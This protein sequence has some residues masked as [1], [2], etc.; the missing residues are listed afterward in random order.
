MLWHIADYICWKFQFFVLCRHTCQWAAW[1]CVMGMFK[2]QWI[3]GRQCIW[4]IFCC[5]V[6][7]VW[8]TSST[9]SVLCGFQ[10]SRLLATRWQSLPFPSPIPLI[11]QNLLSWNIASADSVNQHMQALC[12]ITHPVPSVLN[13]VCW[14][15]KAKCF[16][17]KYLAANFCQRLLAT[18]LVCCCS[19]VLCHCWCGSI[20]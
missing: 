9:R 2:A 10:L 12:S 6:L 1:Y 20:C 18:V 11:L 3:P 4:I 14:A 17:F 16:C 19:F 5:L 8:I 7:S 13:D 15:V